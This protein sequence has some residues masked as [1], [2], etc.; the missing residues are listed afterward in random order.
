MMRPL[1]APGN[2]AGARLPA[3]LPRPSGPGGA[4]EKRSRYAT[5]VLL[6]PDPL[7]L[8]S[9]PACFPSADRHT[10]QTPNTSRTEA[11]SHKIDFRDST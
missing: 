8:R 2:Q 11:A 3:P 5:S 4:W 10:N 7:R 6:P 9:H 1:L